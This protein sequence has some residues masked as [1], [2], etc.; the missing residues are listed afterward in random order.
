[1]KKSERYH[2]AIIAVMNAAEIP[3]NDKV[4]IL[5]TLLDAKGTALFVEKEKENHE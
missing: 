5:E 4:E 1:M 2:V 3:D